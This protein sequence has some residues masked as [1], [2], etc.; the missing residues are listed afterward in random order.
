MHQGQIKTNPGL[1]HTHVTTILYRD[2]TKAKNKN[3]VQTSRPRAHI[4][5]S[6]R[7]FIFLYR[8]DDSAPIP[9]P[10]KPAATV[11]PPKVKATLKYIKSSHRE[12]MCN[13]CMS[14]D[15][16][17][18]HRDLEVWDLIGTVSAN[19]WN[20]VEP[21]L[22]C[23]LRI[24]FAYVTMMLHITK[25]HAYTITSV[26]VAKQTVIDEVYVFSIKYRY[27]HISLKKKHK[28]HLFC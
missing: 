28:L 7:G 20:S 2:N 17:I 6:A 3:G 5:G 18:Y 11:I 12:Y 14:C 19:P 21:D 10:I 1:I 9:T 23:T 25:K 22:G 15:L 16:G 27:S 4:R 26:I 13:F 8:L 24:Y